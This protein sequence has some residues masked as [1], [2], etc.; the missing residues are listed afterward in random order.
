TDYDDPAFATVDLC[1]A[2]V[3]VGATITRQTSPTLVVEGIAVGDEGTVFAA[4]GNP[5]NIASPRSDHLGT[6]NVDTGAITDLGEAIDTLQNDID[7][8]FMAGD[9][10]YGVDVATTLFKIEIFGLDMDDGSKTSSVEGSY[11][12]VAAVPLRIA[13]DG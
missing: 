5:A 10:L 9:A 11:G 4:A 8:L 6:W 2:Q 7:G 12:S 1:T 13:H 3:S